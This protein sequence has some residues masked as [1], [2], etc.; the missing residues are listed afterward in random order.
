MFFM[1]GIYAI[2]LPPIPNHVSLFVILSNSFLC[3]LWIYLK[4]SVNTNEANMDVF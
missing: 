4:K 2:P 3:D 1:G